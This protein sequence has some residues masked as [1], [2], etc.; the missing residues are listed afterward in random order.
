MT[1]A[2][3]LHVLAACGLLSATAAQAVDTSQWAC[4]TCPYEKAGVSGT[5]EAG[6]G[7]V[8][9]D[10]ARYGA[11]N[12][13]NGKSGFVVLNGTLRY[14]D[15]GGI[16]GSGVVDEL[17]LDKRALAAELGKEGAFRIN[18]S[19]AELPHRLEGAGRTPFIGAG[20][21]MQTL[22]A[23]FPAASPAQMPLASTLQPVDLGTQR[24]RSELSALWIAGAEWTHR[25]SLRHEVRDGT[26]VLGGSFFSSS[27]LLAAPVDQTTDQLELSTSY[28]SR[29]LN[30]TL[31]YQASVFRQ[32]ENSLTW[33]NPFNPVL[34]GATRGQLA[35]APSNQFHQLMASGGIELAPAVRL[36]GDVAVGRMRQDEAFLPATLNPTLAP[37]ALPAPSLDGRVETFDSS[38]K[39]TAAPADGLRLNASVARNVRD[40]QTTSRLYPA[41]AAD[42]FLES[43]TRRAPAFSVKQNRF[44]AGA[45]YR[46]GK[47][48][49]VAAG[50]DWDERTRSWQ[51]VVTT[52]D[53]SLWARGSVT[54]TEALVLSL[55]LARAERS[56]SAYGSATWVTALQN[57]LLRKF[58]LA[59]R[60]RETAALRA[61]ITLSETVSI[62]LHVDLSRDNFPDTVLGMTLARNLSGGAD[63]AWSLSDTT[64]LHAYVQGERMRSAQAGSEAFAAPDWWSR[65]HDTAQVLGLGVKHLALKGQLALGGDVVTSRSRANTGVTTQVAESPY[66]TATQARDSLRLHATWKLQEALSIVGRYA[67]ERQAQA[68]WRL[69]GLQ[70][71]TV[72]NLLAL[73]EAPA[74]YRVNVFSVA[75][76]YRY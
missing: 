21:G 20:S 36:S 28:A 19:I 54:P 6:A 29:G 52:H 30:A 47:T 5:L 65:A 61:D 45:D 74:R 2:T 39:L 72:A 68:D 22:P 9:G 15:G 58:N 18:L 26:Q 57:P 27:T 76:R 46:I 33:A 40:N 59:E 48:A 49:S 60:Q 11:D 43:G 75:L 44:K 8:S 56:H 73:G 3:P 34:A 71:D 7:A 31:A 66:P 70:P 51:D 4:A 55:K 63:V 17:G 69:D 23:G 13:L 42:L 24:T 38:L 32:G 50:V 1:H 53:T 10:R 25:V 12:G 67:F 62:G 41:L 14:R 16:Y 64:Q 37:A 35:L